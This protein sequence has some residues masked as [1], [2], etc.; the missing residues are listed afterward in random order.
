MPKAG[1]E[2]IEGNKG[3]YFYLYPFKNL[4]QGPVASMC[5]LNKKIINTK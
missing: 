1:V 5:A 4:I 3:S 2:Q